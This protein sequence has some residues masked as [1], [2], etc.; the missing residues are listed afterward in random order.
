MVDALL[1]F[2]LPDKIYGITV[3][4]WGTLFW[5]SNC[6]AQ[7]QSKRIEF[8]ESVHQGISFDFDKSAKSYFLT[9]RAKFQEHERNCV[10]LP[11][12]ERIGFL[13]NYKLFL[14]RSK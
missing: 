9:E 14:I 11:M 13:T 2:S 7:L 6:V 8:L 10:Y 1:D 12:Q 4:L 3:D 5:D